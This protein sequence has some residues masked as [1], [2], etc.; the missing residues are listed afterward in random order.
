M[1]LNSFQFLK[2]AK[3]EKKSEKNG[4]AEKNPG[5]RKRMQKLGLKGMSNLTL[6]L[7]KKFRAKKKQNPEIKLRK[8]FKTI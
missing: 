2:A 1:F 5:S 4:N 6:E 7:F 8:N 3:N